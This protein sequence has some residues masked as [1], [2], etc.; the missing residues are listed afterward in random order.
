MRKNCLVCGKEFQTYLS[1]VKAGKGKYCSKACCLS[2]TA[3]DGIKGSGNRFKK[4]QMPWSFKGWRYHI[5]RKGRKKY[6]EIYRPDHPFC[7][8]AGYVRE[9]RLVME[10]TL[11]RYL[12][13]GEVV[14]H[15]N[16]NTLDNRPE[17]LEVLAKKDHDRMNTP[18]NIHRR[19]ITA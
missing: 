4:G 13:K 2:V 10:K 6:K 14:H 5:A 1:K 7:T 18:L 16:G 3:L 11:G 17:N 8:A 15:L 12:Q 9:H 19:W